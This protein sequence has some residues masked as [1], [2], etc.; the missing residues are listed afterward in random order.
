MSLEDVST[1]FGYAVFI[2]V[3]LP[4]FVT[5][6]FIIYLAI[7]LIESYNID[8][9]ILGQ[10][11]NLPL[12]EKLLTMTLLGFLIGSIIESADLYIYQLLEGIRFWPN[13]I[14]RRFHDS[15]VEN[16]EDIIK[17]IED[18]EIQMKSPLCS[19]QKLELY[20]QECNLSERLKTYPVTKANI[21]ATD[22]GN[23]LKE[24]ETYPKE[25]YGMDL[26]IFWSR[27]FLFVPEEIKN[28]LD[29]RGAKAD[30]SIYLTFIF[31]IFNPIVGF[32]SYQLWG[33][34]PA[35]IA[36]I[37][38]WFITSKFLY[39]LALRSHLS[40]GRYV[41]AVFDIYR[42]DLANKLNLPTYLCPNEG[43]RVIWKDY[44]EFLE[45]YT[46]QRNLIL[47]RRIK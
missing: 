22:L 37:V 3:F 17:S 31:L 28:E 12:I 10:L 44:G 38:W 25:Q 40:Y 2:R 7:P 15:A 23:I 5:V 34:L 42:I 24:Y 32:R 11:I 29:I 6:G 30:F 47:Q 27:L 8:L 33:T 4:G 18:I 1:S 13:P 26:N 36:L 20:N 35:L 46:S 41:K 9:P 16:Y 39:K 14:W 21:E 45:E 43:E 19:R